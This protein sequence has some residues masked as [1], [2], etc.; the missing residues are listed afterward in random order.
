MLLILKKL[1][2]QKQKTLPEIDSVWSLQN[3]EPHSGLMSCRAQTWGSAASHPKW[4]LYKR[5]EKNYQVDFHQ[6]RLRLMKRLAL[7]N[8]TCH[9][10][11][12][13]NGYN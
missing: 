13:G 7:V 5:Y 2:K 6:S 12:S 1:K 8:S 4:S 10:S 11:C 3:N 9:N